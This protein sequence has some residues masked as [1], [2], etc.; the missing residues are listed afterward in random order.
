KFKILLVVW[1][2]LTVFSSITGVEFPEPYSKFLSW[3]NFVNFDI[4]HIFSVSCILPSV[5]FYERLL[6]TTLT[7]LVLTTGLVLTYQVAK[8][9]AGI[10]SAG[11]IAKRAAWARHVTAGLLL[12]FLIFTSASTL[13][14]KAF[15]CDDAVGDGKSYLRADY[16]I[17]CDSNL[18]TF[19]KGYA[20]LMILVYPI[21]IPALYAAILWS[22][23][24]L[25]NPRMHTAVKSESDATDGAATTADSADG[26]GVRS[27]ASNADTRCTALY[28]SAGPE[29]FY[30]EVLECGRRV[31]L[32]GLLILISPNSPTQVAVACVFAFV[33]LLG[34]E[35]L[36]PHLD[37]A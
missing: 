8:H 14:F 5:N 26:V 4:G 25:L 21:G 12:T 37:Q 23:R 7:P 36:R 11:V 30:Y 35:L 22:K 2:I 31:L 32:T 13:V 19:F 1:Q 27:C 34:F 20:M 3:I 24:E 18:H 33:T 16:S 6:V 29:L 9:R 10:G 17:S 28:S 15:A